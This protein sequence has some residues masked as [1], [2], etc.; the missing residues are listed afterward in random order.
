MLQFAILL[1]IKA[2]WF[3]IVDKTNIKTTLAYTLLSCFD[4]SYLLYRVMDNVTQVSDMVRWYFVIIHTPKIFHDCLNTMYCVNFN[5]LYRQYVPFNLGIFFSKLFNPLYIW[6]TIRMVSKIH[7]Y[8]FSFELSGRLWM[9][10]NRNL[11]PQ[12]A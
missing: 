9:H 4:Q 3:I 11:N 10:A 1:C 5:S 6:Q 8:E 12:N 2:F 7:L